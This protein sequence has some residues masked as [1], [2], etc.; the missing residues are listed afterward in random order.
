MDGQLT[1][2][3]TQPSDAGLYVCEIE[4]GVGYKTVA[5]MLYVRGKDLSIL[6]ETVFLNC[7]SQA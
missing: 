2:I 1:I 5:V 4:N 7:S 6:N 3:N